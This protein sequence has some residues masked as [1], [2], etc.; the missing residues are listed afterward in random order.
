M[1]QTTE[2][3]M[4][5]GVNVDQMYGTLD[6]IKANPPLAKFQFRASNRWL[7]GSHNRSLIQGFYGAG[8]EDA[9][10]T[11]PFVLDAGEPPVLLGANEGPNPAEFALHALAACLTTSLIYVASARGVILDA[12]ESTVEGELDTLGALGIDTSVRNGFE[13]I[14]VVFR[15]KSDAPAEKIAEIVSRARSRSVVFDTISNPV[16]VSVEAVKL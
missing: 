14:R 2:P 9:T 6:A 5:N 15:I 16:P 4:R 10:R 11:T 13:Q 3:R 1:T 12:V 7:G 8:Q